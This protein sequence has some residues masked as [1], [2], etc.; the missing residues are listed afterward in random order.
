MEEINWSAD[1]GDVDKVWLSAEEEGGDDINWSADPERCEGFKGSEKVFALADSM[2]WSALG[3]GL[4]GIG[5]QCSG[6]K[7]QTFFR[8]SSHLEKSS[9]Q[10]PKTTKP[11]RFGTPNNNSTQNPHDQDSHQ[12]IDSPATFGGASTPKPT[13]VDSTRPKTLLQS[14][15]S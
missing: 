2:D 6:P 7:I 9:N 14:S 13:W 15:N 12:N 10:V 8:N 3:D 5:S 1:H 11:S 4:E